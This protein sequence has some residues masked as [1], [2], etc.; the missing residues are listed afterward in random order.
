[1]QG[2]W[3]PRDFGRRRGYRRDIREQLGQQLA[4]QPCHPSANPPVYSLLYTHPPDTF[5]R[6]VVAQPAAR[7]FGTSIF[8]SVR[9]TKPAKATC[10][11]N[12]KALRR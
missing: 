3:R 1:M 6:P 12:S 11:I 7:V 4:H 9:K 10:M 8:R 5:Q 2:N